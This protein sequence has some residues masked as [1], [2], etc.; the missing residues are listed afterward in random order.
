MLLSVLGFHVLLRHLRHRCS[1]CWSWPSC[2]WTFYQFPFGSQGR[3]NFV[4]S[5]HH[6][7]ENIWKSWQ[8]TT[9][10]K[11]SRFRVMRAK[12][13]AKQ[14]RNSCAD[15]ARWPWWSFIVAIQLPCQDMTKT[16]PLANPSPRVSPNLWK[17]A[18]VQADDLPVPVW[19]AG[20]VEL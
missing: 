19:K 9:A 6:P 13:V 18:G 2:R 20:R 7:Y 11:E 12:I 8:P 10:V 3:T 5:L 1:G 17:V 14:G 16:T 15:C 4:V